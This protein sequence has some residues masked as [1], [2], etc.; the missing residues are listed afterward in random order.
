MLWVDVE[1]LPIPKADGWERYAGNNW[2]VGG[3]IDRADNHQGWLCYKMEGNTSSQAVQVNF[4]NMCLLIIGGVISGI[5]LVILLILCYRLICRSNSRGSNTSLNQQQSPPN[6]QLCS[7]NQP[8]C[9]PN[10]QQI[11]SPNQQQFS[12]G[13]PQY[14]PIQPQC[15]SKQQLYSP[16]QQ[17]YRSGQQP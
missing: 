11:Y 15:S 10:Q 9:S 8:P 12:H 5:L 14:P 3:R 1:G 4:I 2:T 6:Q 16:N 7:P 17:Q 13:Q